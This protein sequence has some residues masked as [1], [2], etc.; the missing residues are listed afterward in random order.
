MSGN[1]A[2]GPGGAIGYHNTGAGSL[3][4]VTIS[5]NTATGNGGG[6]WTDVPITITNST[7]TLNNA[8]D[9]GGI[10]TEHNNRDHL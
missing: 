2:A 5:G 8:N 9:G 4:N 10:S 7:I 3:T 1:T 6:L